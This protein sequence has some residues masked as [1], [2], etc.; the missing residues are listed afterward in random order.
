MEVLEPKDGPSAIAISRAYTRGV[1]GRTPLMQVPGNE[2][3]RQAV[4]AFT[5]AELLAA[6]KLDLKFTPSKRLYREIIRRDLWELA[7]GYPIL[8]RH[9]EIFLEARSSCRR[10]P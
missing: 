1:G 2:L 10:H 8:I 5:A 4:G 3:Y 7:L 6:V 9:C